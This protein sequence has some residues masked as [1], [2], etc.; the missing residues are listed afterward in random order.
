MAKLISQT[1]FGQVGLHVLGAA[2]ELLVPW[3]HHEQ[4]AGGTLLY[5]L[6]QK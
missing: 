5:P 4:R 3:A 6:I 1:C 2:N